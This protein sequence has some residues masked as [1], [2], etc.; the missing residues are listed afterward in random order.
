MPLILHTTRWQADLQFRDG[1]LH[2]LM[3][4]SADEHRWKSD[5]L[6]LNAACKQENTRGLDSIV[7]LQT[8]CRSVHAFR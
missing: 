8:A 3:R 5:P 7:K 4:H 6:C 1:T 2:S